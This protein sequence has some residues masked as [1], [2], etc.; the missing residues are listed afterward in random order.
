[1]GNELSRPGGV[2][3]APCVSRNPRFQALFEAPGR[4]PTSPAGR[5]PASG[6]GQQLGN[7]LETEPRPT[8][9]S[10]QTTGPLR[11]W[12]HS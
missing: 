5:Q 11:D 4:S 9:E 2:L 7:G 6:F 3:N 8:G 1:M 12:N 10:D